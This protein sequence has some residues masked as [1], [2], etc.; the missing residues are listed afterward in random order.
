MTSTAQAALDR[1]AAA[2]AL[3][4]VGLR[5]TAPRVAILATLTRD[6]R[7]PSAEHLYEALRDELPGLSLSTVYQALEAFIQNG[8][9]R[10]IHG[11]HERLRVDGTPGDHDH[12]ICVECG[13]V[14]DIDRAHYERPAPPDE[15]P[16]G[17][18]VEGLRFE[19]DVLCPDCDTD[20]S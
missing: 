11:V 1:S 13:E 16:G 2:E 15:L 14:F 8:L 17:L 7:H 4:E 10:R 3:R 6:R 5:V 18:R 9:V 20:E 19:Y 12:A